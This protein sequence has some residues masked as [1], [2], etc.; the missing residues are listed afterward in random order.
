[1]RF[2]RP[3][4]F[5]VKS[6]SPKMLVVAM[7]VIIWYLVSKI[8]KKFNIIWHKNYTS[9]RNIQHVKKV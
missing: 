8:V 7:V 3:R 1:M 5:I 6:A 4:H 2:Q 9:I